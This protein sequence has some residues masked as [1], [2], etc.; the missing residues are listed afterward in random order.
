MADPEIE[1]ILQKT[2]GLKVSTIGKATLDRAIERRINALAL[3]D[4]TAYLVHLK[5]SALELN[6]LIEEVIIP[7]TWFFRDRRPFDLLDRQI[8]TWKRSKEKLFLRLLSAPCSS[9]EE[10]FS[11]VIALLDAGWPVNKFQVMALDI[12]ARSLTRAQQAEYTRNSFRGDNLAFRDCYFEQVGNKYILKKEARSKVQFLQ[13][14]LLN[15]A[16]MAS[17]GLFDVIFCKNVLIYLDNQARKTALK[18]LADLLVFDGLIFVGHAETTI[19]K[20]SGFIPLSHAH[21]FAFRKP[22]AGP[23]PAPVQPRQP[24]AATLPEYGG[25]SPRRKRA[26]PQRPPPPKKAAPPPPKKAAAGGVSKTAVPDLDAARRHADQGH[27]KEARMIC[28]AFL[29][30][31]GPSSRAFFLLGVI[32]NAAGEYQAAAKMLRKVLYLEPGHLDALV[33]LA[34]QAERSGNLADAK[35]FRRRIERLEKESPGSETFIAGS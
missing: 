14:N 15:H 31:R 23:Q 27:L 24:V 2:M 26:A 7:E 10:P 34:L 6:E 25:Q 32:H 17:L 16:F 19:L 20:D 29:K 1:A 9:G 4:E 12:S 3:A 28:E 13:G 18:T 11:L 21:A 5:S 35:A 30:T 22:T 8:K 33:L